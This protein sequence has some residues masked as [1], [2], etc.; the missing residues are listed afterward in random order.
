MFGQTKYSADDKS[1]DAALARIAEGD[2]SALSI[3]YELYGKLIYSAAYQITN[4]SHTAQ[5]VLQDVMVAV[6]E[7]AGQYS[8]GTNPRAWIMTVTRNIAID[9]LR[10]CHN[11]RTDLTENVQNLAIKEGCEDSLV[12]K[13]ALA[14]LSADERIILYGKLY[15]GLSH[16]ELG[17]MLGINRVACSARYRR[18]IKKLKK[19]FM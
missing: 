8:C 4:D 12:I 5:D 15:A 14:A 6:A 16:G 11:S 2:V 18:A 7:K 3:I 10:L 9:K 1:C 19:Y 17:K 13:E